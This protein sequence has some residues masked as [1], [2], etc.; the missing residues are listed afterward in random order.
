MKVQILCG[1]PLELD[2][3]LKI[4]TCAGEL[5]LDSAGRQFMPG[6]IET[7][8]AQF[9]EEHRHHCKAGDRA[10]VLPPLSDDEARKLVD[11]YIDMEAGGVLE[12]EEETFTPIEGIVYEDKGDDLARI[13]GVLAFGEDDPID[14][15]DDESQPQLPLEDDP[16]QGD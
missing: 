12:G 2:A 3:G 6:E 9:Y 11:N 15:L 5:T 10:E 16:N 13:L 1:Q 14:G 8:L 4:E 7:L